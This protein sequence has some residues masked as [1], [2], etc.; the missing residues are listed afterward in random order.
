MRWWAQSGQDFAFPG[1][2]FIGP[3]RLPGTAAFGPPRR[4]TDLLLA[5]VA[6]GGKA[7]RVTGRMRDGLIADL[8]FWRAG[9]MVLADGEPRADVLRKL[10]TDLVG[11][12]VRTGG[13]TV[14]DVSALAT[15]VT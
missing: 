13:V 2:Y 5:A 14:W 3:G 11:T 6:E 9:A 7:P 10:V 15:A 8:R 1:G 4:P 12:G